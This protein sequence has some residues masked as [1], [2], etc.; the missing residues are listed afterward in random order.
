MVVPLKKQRGGKFLIPWE[1]PDQMNLDE[2]TCLFIWGLKKKKMGYALL[3]I[4]AA[5]PFQFEWSRTRTAP[6]L[7]NFANNV[8]LHTG[9]RLISA[10]R[11]N[12][13][14]ITV[15]RLHTCQELLSH[16]VSVVYSSYREWIHALQGLFFF[17]SK[18]LDL[19]IA[20]S[21]GP[22]TFRC[23]LESIGVKSNTAF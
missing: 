14:Q 9:A 2:V 1:D 11:C 5:A 22:N 8:C 10:T 20:V 6:H 12:S 16:G 19:E 7:K 13:L 18:E 3:F 17:S 23:M 4:K 21:L 15:T